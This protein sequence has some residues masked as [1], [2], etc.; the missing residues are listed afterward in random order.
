MN[1]QSMT[2]SGSDLLRIETLSTRLNLSE[3]RAVEAAAEVG[4]ITRSEW[5]RDAALAY[6]RHPH[7]KSTTPIDVK[8]LEEVMGLR[9]LM[10]NL[11]AG[12]NPRMALQTVHQLM[13]HADSVKYNAAA[14]VVRCSSEGQDTK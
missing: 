8:I 5:L 12:V 9:F 11:F 4:G 14:K 13:A 10:V 2:S 7:Q 6:L 1:S 3:M